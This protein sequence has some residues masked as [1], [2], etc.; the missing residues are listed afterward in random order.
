[1]SQP[2]SGE[3]LSPTP[4]S[5]D[6]AWETTWPLY[7]VFPLT[8]LFFTGLYLIGPKF[9]PK[10]IRRYKSMGDLNRKCWRQNTNAMLHTLV[11]CPVLLV[12]ILTDEDLRVN[13]PL[14]PHHNT[15]GYIALSWSLGYF[16]FTLPWSAHL[17]FV[18]G[19]RRAT[20]LPL[21]IHHVIVW[22][23]ALTYL[24][25]RTCALYGAV[26]FAAMEFTNWFFIAHILQQMARSQMQRLWTANYVILVLV[27]VIGMRLILCTYMFI[28]FSYDLSQ[29]SS[30]S[31]G[32]WV[33]IILQY[34]IFA[35]VVVLSWVFIYN[36]IKEAELDKMVIRKLGL[37]KP[38]G[39]KSPKVEH[40]EE[41]SRSRTGSPKKQVSATPGTA[42]RS[43]GGP[44]GGGQV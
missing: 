16:T 33:L 37:D 19:E 12:A 18:K 26:A 32:E 35:M 43:G 38:R 5:I 2:G 9:W 40:N 31:G 41:P 8:A 11:L 10:L 24:I 27:G 13:R 1:M 28:L 23:A 39:S 25:G 36:G 6:L 21:L 15:L 7:T 42:V 17:Y 44:P 3:A 29:F 30:D 34:A 14:H 22:I 4:F 20:N